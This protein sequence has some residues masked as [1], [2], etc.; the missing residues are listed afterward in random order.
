GTQ[1]QT[2]AADTARQLVAE[3]LQG[4][5][6]G[7]ELIPPIAGKASPIGLRRRVVVREGRQ[8]LADVLQ[9]QTYALSSTNER[10]PAQHR[11][12]ITPL[13]PARTLRGNQPAL[14]SEERRVG[15]ECRSRRGRRH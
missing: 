12:R 14:R 1:R 5:D 2:A 10:D 11:P 9:T 4:V 3:P 13:V 7:I 6:A 15:K 8:R